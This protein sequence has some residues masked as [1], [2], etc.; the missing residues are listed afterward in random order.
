MVAVEQ[1]E[2]AIDPVC[3]MKVALPNKKSSADHDGD[4]YYFCCAGCARKFE[5]DPQGY[6][7]GSAQAVIQLYLRGT[8]IRFAPTAFT[9]TH[10]RVGLFA[11][12]G[13]DAAGAMIFEAASD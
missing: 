7:D 5:G 8:N 9:Q 10:Q 2:Y 12:C 1:D 3:G 13:V 4:T 6:L 11:A